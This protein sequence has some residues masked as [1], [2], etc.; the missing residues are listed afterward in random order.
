MKDFD[1]QLSAWKLLPLW[2]LYVL[3]FIVPFQS[4]LWESFSLLDWRSFFYFII[5]YLIF[6]LYF[7]LT[8][9]YV[10]YKLIVGHI[11]IRGEAVKFKGSALKYIQHLI[12]GSIYMLP[13]FGLYL[14]FFVKQLY[15]YLVKK[16]SYNGIRLRFSGKVWKLICVILFSYLVPIAGIVYAFF[17]FVTAHPLSVLD[18]AQYAWHA[19]NLIWLP[20]SYFTFKWMCDIVYLDQRWQLRSSVWNDLLFFLQMAILTLLTFGL[21]LPMAM[22]KIYAYLVHGIRL[23]A[24]GKQPM[25][26]YRS[27]DWTDYSFVLKNLIF[28]VITFGFYVPW[29]VCNTIQYLLNRTYFLELKI[30]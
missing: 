13:S 9:W 29:A 30:K 12:L 3:L 4:I 7:Q 19:I 26:Q 5:A 27:E 15:S 14:P 8:F 17:R 2:L 6:L 20:A 10:I 18:A 16:T 23:K 1:F 21:Y 22:I 25:I 11:I 24:R 28:C